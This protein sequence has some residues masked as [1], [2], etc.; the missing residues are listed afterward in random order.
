MFAFCLPYTAYPIPWLEEGAL[1]LLGLFLFNLIIGIVCA[2]AYSVVSLFFIIKQIHT[3]VWWAQVFIFGV[4]LTLAEI[5]RSFLIS[6]ILSGNGGWIGLHWSGETIGNALSVT[7]FIEYAYFGGAYMLTF[8]VGISLTTIKYILV[9]PYKKIYYTPFIIMIIGLICIHYLIPVRGPKDPVTIG[10]VS[11]MFSMTKRGDN[12][13][14]DFA[15]YF[16]ILYRSLESLTHNRPDIIA[17]PE[18]SQ[19]TKYLVGQIGEQLHTRLPGVLFVDG[20]TIT[21]EGKLSNVSIFY[22]KGVPSPIQAHKQFMFPFNE[23]IPSLFMPVFRHFIN[24]EELALFTKNHTYAP[25]FLPRT[26]LYNGVRIGTLLC[27]EIVSFETVRRLGKEKPDIIIHQAYL[28]LFKKSAIYDAHLRSFSKVAA[29]QLRTP[30]VG[31]VN[32]LPS[33]IISPHGKII[34]TLYTDK[35]DDVDSGVYKISQDEILRISK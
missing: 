18:D 29:A 10:T 11:T 32:G 12:V 17:L 31:S 9:A 22:K 3:L 7:P 30:F 21:Y 8:L 2:G 28:G 13:N 15:K 35:D 26:Y 34:D 16:A 24:K 6:F 27:S 33:Y 20:D 4:T 1:Q 23:Y 5:L 25:V 19:F 14:E